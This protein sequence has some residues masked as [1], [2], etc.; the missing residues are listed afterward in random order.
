MNLALEVGTSTEF[1]T[2]MTREL[3]VDTT[4]PT[5]QPVVEQRRVTELPL[6]GRNAAQLTLLTAGSVNSPN[7]GAD[8]GFT[9]TF[10]D[11]VTISA[12]GA[13][14]NM[15]SYQLDSGNY[16]DE[17]TNVNHSRATEEG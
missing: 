2:V 16:V 1:V 14:Q 8:Q 5:L 10:P 13:R 17:Y 6:N 11:A 7:G 4:T 9:K 3:Q 15:V 12:N